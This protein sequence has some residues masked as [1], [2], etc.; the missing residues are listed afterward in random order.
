MQSYVREQLRGMHVTGK[1]RWGTFQPWLSLIVRLGMVGILIAAAVPKMSDLPA[2]VRAVRAYR[3]LPEAVVPLVGQ[4]LPFLE[5]LLAVFL[6]LGLFTRLSA[7]AWLAM[8]VGFSIGV[9]WVWIKGYSIDCGCFGG[10]GDVAEGTTNYPMHM[11]E[12]VGF[13]V[14]GTYLLVFPRSKF[15]LDGW[16][17]P[18][19]INDAPITVAHTPE[20]P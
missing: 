13:I 10:G 2:S 4:L 19:P 17:N 1:Q 20:G 9:I 3:L 14:L 5:L 11:L 18:A 16:M 6:I 7:V 15:S 8:M 12:R